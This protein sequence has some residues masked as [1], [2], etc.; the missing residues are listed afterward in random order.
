M[1]LILTQ[2]QQDVLRNTRNIMG[3]LRDTLAQSNATDD[4]RAAL[5][6]SIRRLDELFLLV[7][8]GEFNSGKST[9]IN[10]LLGADLLEEG[11]TPTTSQIHLL[12]HG[13]TAGQRPGEQG[14][15]IQTAPVDLLRTINIVD[16]PG[17][18]A[19]IR[20]HEALTAE[21]IPRSDLVLFVTSADRPFSES[22]RAFLSD[23]RAWG[24][25][26]VL[27]VN[28]VDILTPQDV[29]KVL[30]F[31]QNAATKLLEDT[32]AVFAI[33]ARHAKRAKSGTPEL[34][35]ASR[36][37]P[38]ETYIR[39]SLDDIGRFQ[40]KLL[41]PLGV[42]KTL[43][44]RQLQATQADLDELQVDATLL[45]D[46]EH[47]MGVYHSDMERNFQARIGEIDNLLFQMEKRGNDFFDDMIRIGRITDLM[48]KERVQLEFEQKVVADTPD[49]INKR[50][51]E[52]IDWIVEQELR[53]WTA[54]ADHLQTR[55]AQYAERIIGHSGARDSQLAYD[56]QRL[57]DSIGT[58][59]RDAVDSY[60]SHAEA[61][62]LA[63]SAREAVAATGLLGV[64]GT[65]A[66]VAIV[67]FTA[68]DV[69]GILTGAAALTFGLLVLPRRR[70]RAKQELA[71][72]LADLRD[73]LVTS[74][75]TQFER[76]MRRSVQRIED[77]I[78]PYSRFVRAEQEKVTKRLASFE[79]VEAHLIGLENQVK[80]LG[81]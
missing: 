72:K 46:I 64:A 7:V 18:N 77:S 31:V 56:R 4:E 54:V 8:A 68:L 39:D 51:S 12:T 37:E 41:N 19:I 21:F 36:F 66:G 14:I 24:K 30:D 45:E 27:V 58:A 23:I 5:A 22:E 1:D 2:T 81:D 43:V 80:L 20:E 53:Q 38:L 35:A 76:E 62:R 55:R 40:L 67:A 16:T 33:S 57:I 60:D 73:K 10:A 63:D 29:D 48:R 17:T 25:K 65:A 50:I 34:W 79:E 52:L 9:F 42:G 47:Q 74:L 70:H 75:T 49:Q 15:W 26:I 13:S 61:A 3:H 78:A 44:R 11:V 69:T 32:P 28:K 71:Q 59:T 6:E